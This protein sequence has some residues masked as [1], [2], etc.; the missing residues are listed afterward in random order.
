MITCV[1]VNSNAHQE[2]ADPPPVGPKEAPKQAKKKV[3]HDSYINSYLDANPKTKYYV[4]KFVNGGLE[5][6]LALAM[7]V[8]TANYF[9]GAHRNKTLSKQWLNKLR[10]LLFANFAVIGT[11][12][13]QLKSA[14]EID[15]EDSTSN[16]YRLYCTGREKLHYAYFTLELK[17]RQNFFSMVVSFFTC[18]SIF[19]SPISTDNL[20]LEIPIDRKEVESHASEKLISEVLII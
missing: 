17:N 3:G 9:Y 20:W 15:F 14:S 16:V 12:G 10:P 8:F 11:Q 18:R 6:S 5:L 1:I 13:R 19:R 7:A 4:D 2:M